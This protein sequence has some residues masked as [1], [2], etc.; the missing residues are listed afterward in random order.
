MR[1]DAQS[2]AWGAMALVVVSNLVYHVA[3]KTIPKTANPLASV[4]VSYVVAF[5]L[6]LALLPAFGAEEGLVASLKTLN[7]SSVLVG[8]S[9]VGVEFGFLLVYRSGWPI[10]VASLACSVLVALVFVPLGAVAFREGW[11]LEKT[12]GLVLCVAGLFL[13]NRR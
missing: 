12:G 11:S 3:Q 10:N 7:L 5:L 13:L 2:L 1:K 6:T 8:L 9:I 4:L